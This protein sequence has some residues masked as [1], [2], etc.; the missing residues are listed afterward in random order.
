M[1]RDAIVCVDDEAIILMSI[2][3]EIKD[4]FGGQFRYETAI[5]ADEALLI[6]DNMLKK[7]INPVIIITDLSL[8][9]KKGD[10]LIA[11]AAVKCPTIKGIIIT[12]QADNETVEKLKD[13]SNIFSYII[14]PWRKNE[15][16][17]VIEK[18]LAK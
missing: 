13:N 10:Q 6:I 9:G 16:I 17:H 12:G 11:E 14:K 3:Q 2:K 7:G 8:N 1:T 15:L 18:A 5:D 4:H